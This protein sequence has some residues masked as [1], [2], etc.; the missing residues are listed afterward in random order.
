MR[1]AVIHDWLVTWGG[2]ERVLEQILACYPEA[3]LYCIVEGLDDDRRHILTGR[4]VHMSFIQSLPGATRNYWYYTPLMPLAIEQFDLAKYDLVISSSHA[5][6][7]GVIGHPDQLH[8]SYVHS[9]MRFAWDLQSSYLEQFG[10]KS[11]LRSA[12]ARVF[13]HYLRIWDRGAVNGVDTIL[14]CSHFSARRVAKAYRRTGVAVYPPVDTERFVLAMARG[15]YFLAG[16]RMNPFKRIDLVVRAFTGL[17]NEK[18]VVIGDGPD[19]ARLKGLAPSNVEFAGHLTDAEVV[20]MMQGARAFVHAAKEDFGIAMAEAQACGT[21][22]IAFAEGGAGEIIRNLGG[23]AS[24]TGVLFDEQTVESVRDGIRRFI[25]EGSKIDPWACHENAQRFG[26]ERF[27]QEIVEQVR[28][29][30][31]RRNGP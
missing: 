18:L 10:F 8:V 27:R 5:V 7:L 26:A 28:I 2:A 13:F 15:D 19:Y 25:T 23:S 20:V 24:P 16:S 6:A 14:T 3:D 30:Q 11:G 21:P 29:S 12:V 9:P 4:A 1:V 31:T 22:V 17:P